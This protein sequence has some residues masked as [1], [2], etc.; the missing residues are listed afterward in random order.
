ME[1]YKVKGKVSPHTRGFS[2]WFEFKK[3]LGVNS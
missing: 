1:K 3:K 2:F